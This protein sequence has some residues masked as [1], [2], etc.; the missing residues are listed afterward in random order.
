MYGCLQKL[1]HENGHHTFY[2]IV[3]N[4]HVGILSMSSNIGGSLNVNHGKGMTSK[5]TKVLNLFSLLYKGFMK[6]V[7]NILLEVN[8]ENILRFQL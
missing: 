3:I 8:N 4:Y 6:E 2:N 1:Q 7:L 5:L